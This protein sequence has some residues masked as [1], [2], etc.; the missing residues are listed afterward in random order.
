[1]KRLTLTLLGLGV[2]AG[3]N[4]GPN[5]T[6]IE[7]IQN[8]MDQVSVKSQDW[9]PA[10]GD[11][12]QMRMPPEGAI[13]RGHAP[14]KY[15]DDPGGA[16][17]DVNPLAGDRSPEMLTFGRKYYDIYCT[18]CHGADGAGAGPVAEQMAVKPRN[19][20]SPEALAYTD[21]RIYYAITA[22][23]G[24]MGSYAS[25]IPDVKTRWAIVNYVRSL[26]KK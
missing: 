6:N 24:V 16:E 12:G 25:Q 18:V 8:M 14:Y 3:C 17:R 4:A 1:M 26:Q 2:L 11:K 9:N 22:G 5:R 20:V 21:G 19:L 15:A 7:V 23:R 10:E 13:A